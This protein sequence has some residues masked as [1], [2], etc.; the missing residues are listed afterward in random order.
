MISYKIFNRLQGKDRMENV[1]ITGGAGFIGSHLA[2]GLVSRGKRVRV[3]DN[4][5]SG[6]RE[7]VQ[8]F[9][10]Q[11]ELLE[12]DVRNQG[13]C[14]KAVTGCDAVFHLSAIPSVP[15]SIS[16]PLLTHEVN[17]T[18]TLNLLTAAKNA[19]VKRFVLASSSAIY[20]DSEV[21]PKTEDMLPKPL[22]PYAL[23]KLG[24]EFYLQLFHRLFGIETV[25]LRFFNV[26]GPQQDPKS[27]YAAVI[28]KFITLMLEGKHPT[29]FGDGRQTRDFTYVSD[30]VQGLMLAGEKPE[31]VGRVLNVACGIKFNLLTLVSVLN[32]VLGTSLQPKFT[33][34]HPGEVK[35]SQADISG[36]TKCLGFVPE[37]S[38]KDGLAKTVEWYKEKMKAV[39]R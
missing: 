9:L 19:G 6:N 37:V 11:I 21:L 5:S 30:V 36:A 8:K 12:G 25:S 13:D 3:L 32:G 38:F 29:I 1:V 14:D 10:S 20:G 28:P 23:H 18:G 35:D 17:L 34:P 31:A 16:E 26:F 2:A 4:F 7:N 39:K 22:S 15:R 24:S 33:P 27:E